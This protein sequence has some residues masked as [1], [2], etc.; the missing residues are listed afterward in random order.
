MKQPRERVKLWAMRIDHVAHISRD[1]H[2]THLFYKGILGLKLVQACSG[3]ELMLVY[4]LPDGG[5]LVFTAAKE[6][7]PI[8]V[9]DVPWERRH[10]GLTLATRVEFESWLQRLREHGVRHRLLDDERIYFSAPDGLVLEL[11][12]AS[13]MAADPAAEEVLA[14]WP[15]D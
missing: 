7:V 12:V 9:D 2:A 4:A 10:V 11:E 6:S 1:P 3:R 14:R 8:P 15:R 5:S 13:P